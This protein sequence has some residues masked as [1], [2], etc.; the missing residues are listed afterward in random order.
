MGEVAA[1]AMEAAR[2]S[3]ASSGGNNQGGETGEAAMT[4]KMVSRAS[5]GVGGSNTRATARQWQRARRQRKQCRRR[6]LCLRSTAVTINDNDDGDGA[7]AVT[8][9]QGDQ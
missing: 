7:V 6:G 4:E 1:A 2:D 9:R 5:L 8:A 3:L